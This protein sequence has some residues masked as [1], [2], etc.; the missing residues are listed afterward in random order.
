MSQTVLD[1]IDADIAELA[2]L[3]PQPAPELAFGSDLS[4]VTDLTPDA[5]ELDPAD[6]RGIGEATIRRLTTARRVLVDD[7][8]YGID[9]RS[10]LNTATSATELRD[11]AGQIRVESLKDD[12]I[13]DIDVTVTQ[14]RPEALVIALRITP[15]DPRQHPFALTFGVTSGALT[16]ESIG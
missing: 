6:R 5:A 13:D 1:A 7:P 12:R 3:V 11:I 9:V 14:P 8:D 4:C 2:R 10:F 15:L 16:L